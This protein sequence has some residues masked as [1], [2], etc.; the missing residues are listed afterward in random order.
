VALLANVYDVPPVAPQPPWQVARLAPATVWWVLWRGSTV[1]QS[2]LS[3]YFARWLPPNALYNWI[4]APGTYQNKAF[5][6]GNYLFWL[7]HALD[8]TAVPD[9][10]YRLEIAADDT[11][12]NIGA[13][14]IDLTVANG[15]DAQAAQPYAPAFSL[16]LLRPS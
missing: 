13:Q 11:R 5:R 1:M 6:P 7:D 16:P 3:A 4:Y 14:S 9:G 15:H 8:T 12:G 2:S 10:T